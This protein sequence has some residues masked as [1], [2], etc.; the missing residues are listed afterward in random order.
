MFDLEEQKAVL[1]LIDSVIKAD[2]SINIQEADFLEEMISTLSFDAKN[3][4]NLSKISYKLSIN[5]VSQMGEEKKDAILKYLTAVSEVDNEINSS[6][7]KVIN[8]IKKLI[9]TK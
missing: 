8:Q 5:L 4:N 2:G 7:I 6:E 1:K 9:Y 3:L